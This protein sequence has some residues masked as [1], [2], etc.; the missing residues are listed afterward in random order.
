MK[1]N[2]GRNG[3][4]IVCA[5]AALGVAGGAAAAVIV[6]DTHEQAAHAVMMSVHRGEIEEAQLAL[7]RATS[8]EVRAFAQKLL[9]EHTAA[10]MR[11]Q[12]LLVGMVRAEED[13]RNANTNA[14]GRGDAFEG[15]G[16]GAY[17]GGANRGVNDRATQAARPQ[18]DPTVP[19]TGASTSKVTQQEQGDARA[20]GAATGNDST[21]NSARDPNTA[22]PGLGSG[23]AQEGRGQGAY[24]GGENRGIADRRDQPARQQ[25]DPTVPSNVGSTSRVAQGTPGNGTS[26]NA[27]SLR[28][29]IIGQRMSDLLVQNSYS[30]PIIDSHMQAMTQLGALNGAAFDRAFAARQ[31]AAHEYALRAIDTILPSAREHASRQTTAMLTQMRVSVTQHLEHARQLQARTR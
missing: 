12:E 30:R 13:R 20:T 5:M 29:Q 31:V 10:M 11:Q 1:I 28:D 8:P 26:D 7:G 3:M 14:P 21:R 24:V 2:A 27:M 9:D 15:R 4:A 18:Y 25:Y 19:G 23:V 6:D 22:A 16:M 17:L